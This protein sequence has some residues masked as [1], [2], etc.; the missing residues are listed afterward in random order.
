MGIN[1]VSLLLFIINIYKSLCFGISPP[2]AL[3]W[4]S[5]EIH[6]VLYDNKSKMLVFSGANDIFT[7]INDE[8]NES[9]TVIEW[10]DKTYLSEGKSMTIT[11]L[12]PSNVDYS[13]TCGLNHLTVIKAKGA[14]FIKYTNEYIPFSIEYKYSFVE[15]EPK[16]FF[17]AY[18][19]QHPITKEWSYV[20]E[21]LE[22]SIIYET[23]RPEILAPYKRE[24]KPIN[25]PEVIN[26]IF[27][28]V[29][30]CACIKDYILKIFILSPQTQILK[31]FEIAS[32][33]PTEYKVLNLNNTITVFTL[34]SSSFQGAKITKTGTN[35]YDVGSRVTFISKSNLVAFAVVVL[36][37]KEFL[38]AVT[39]NNEIYYQKAFSN[40]FRSNT[41]YLTLAIGSANLIKVSFGNFTEKS[42]VMI[43][44]DYN[45]ANYLYLIDYF[46][47]VD[48]KHYKLVSGENMP[49]ARFHEKSIDSTYAL[50]LANSDSNIK[51]YNPTY[52]FIQDGNLHFPSNVG[53]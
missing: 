11:A 8:L 19:S 48:N 12:T 1:C 37:E 26:C 24:I 36:S 52:T 28:E 14:S 4:K 10:K 20:T 13:I 42:I 40:Y 35:S 6:Q 22:I 29:F 2:I 18:T 32:S 47:C 51:N 43:V 34:T 3:Q 16:R 25:Q 46:T 41:E 50:K 53:V 38:F 7:Y 17:I 23:G 9:S 5:K 31:E 15:I 39:S 27:S 30:Y 49:L 21:I 33:I 45:K 44:H